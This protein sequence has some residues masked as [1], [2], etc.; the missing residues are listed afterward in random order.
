VKD[1]VWEGKGLSAWGKEPALSK[2]VN[3]QHIIC[4]VG[5]LKHQVTHYFES[6]ITL[7]LVVGP[8]WK[9]SQSSWCP[10]KCS[11]LHSRLYTLVHTF[12]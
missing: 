6:G 10:I 11:I 8:H 1:R 9:L 7:V 12:L 5:T 3:L 2:G 4:S